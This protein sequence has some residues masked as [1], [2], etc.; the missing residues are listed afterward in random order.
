MNDR[1]TQQGSSR[2]IPWPPFKAD[3]ISGRFGMIYFREDDG[4][5]RL[6]SVKIKGQNFVRFVSS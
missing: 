2:R 4:R 5:Y 3:S 6:D 1:G